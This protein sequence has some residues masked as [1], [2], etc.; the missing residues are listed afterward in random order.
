MDYGHKWTDNELKKLEKRIRKEY[1]QAAKEVE[2]K[3]DKYLERF[4]AKDEIKRHELQAGKI[5][6]EEYRQ[7]VTG[8]ILV[9]ERWAEMQQNLAEDIHRTNLKTASMTREFSYDAYAMNFN[10]GTFEAESGSGVD[11]A[12]TLYD[13]STVERLIR[14]N[15]D[16]LP[17]PGKKTAK[18][19]A[20]GKDVLWNKQVIQ[21]VMT[22]SILQGESIPKIAKRLASEV[23]DSNMKAAIRNAR[24]MTT[25]AENAGRVDSYIRAE[26]MGIQMRQ[27]WLAGHDTR[28][29]HEH[30]LLDGQIVD[31]NKP[32]Q[33]NGY[34]IRFPGDPTAA[35]EMV[36]NCRCALVGIV[37]GSKGEE[38]YNELNKNAKIR[39]AEGMTYEE[40][41]NEHAKP[42]PP[43]NAENTRISRLQELLKR[44]LSNGEL[45]EEQVIE[46]GQLMQEQ[47]KPVKQQWKERKETLKTE[48]QEAYQEFNDHLG[49]S[50]KLQR[51]VKNANVTLSTPAGGAEYKGWSP[52][53]KRW[54]DN[55]TFTMKERFNLDISIKDN[56]TLESYLKR[57][58][59]LSHEYLDKYLGAYDRYD[60]LWSE[61]ENISKTYAQS[62]K[63]ELS[64]VRDMG[65]SAE[66][67]NEVSNHLL[68][69]S[70][71]KKVVIEAYDFYPSEWISNSAATSS[72]TPKKVNRGFYSHRNEVIAISGDGDARSVETA[73]HE[74]GHRFER[75]QDLRGYEGDFYNRRTAGESLQWL[76]GNYKKD[77]MSRF[78]KFVNSYMGKDYG[79]SAYELCSMGFQYA[80]MQPQTLEA[81]P[82]MEAWILGMLATC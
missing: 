30:R 1:Q 42:E 50:E 12:F 39:G 22:Q 10:Y 2:Q 44:R 4:A 26:N 66:L 37:K 5:T 3:L 38:E 53:A 32:F 40:W 11:T 72:L 65:M 77:E 34:K 49:A 14:D 80:Y 20:E 64:K 46:A 81:D 59:E 18:R 36:Y 7:W 43:E 52:E 68:G 23:G 76:G 47:L 16:M 73:I 69:R 48:L 19:I 45:T 70:P 41:R 78:D 9:G 24:T 25:G 75:T 54:L 28:T 8:Q 74:L 27:Q 71:M 61:N 62:L 31:V 15:P 29:R 58:D 21:S 6:E 60:K 33:V 55:M 79:G 56:E 13:R 57:I 51:F 82:D 17:P 67:R 63:A 35:P